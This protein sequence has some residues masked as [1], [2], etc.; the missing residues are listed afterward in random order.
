M[1]TSAYLGIPFISN[2]QNTP[3]ITHNIGIVMLQ[4]LALGAIA[5]Q[6]AAP[7]SPADG[8]TYIVGSAG[9]GAFAGQSNKVAT[10][11][12]GWYF[13]PGFDSDGAAIPMG[14]AQEGLTLYVRGEGGLVTW[15]GAHWY[16]SVPAVSA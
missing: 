14:A 15:D 13:I 2:Q 16:A 8:D 1:T 6:D 5:I 7:G 12:G 3:E 10:Y 9:S 11:M 4:A